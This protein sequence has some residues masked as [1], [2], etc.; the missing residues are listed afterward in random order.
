MLDK[1]NR[2]FGDLVIRWLEV[3][4]W[5]DPITWKISLLKETP[6][7]AELI[8]YEHPNHENPRIFDLTVPRLL[9]GS[10]L[11][12]ELILTDSQV[13]PAHVSLELRH[14]YWV[15]QDLGS[16]HG[17]S[18]NNEVIHEPYILE[19]KDIIQ[20]GAAKLEFHEEVIKPTK[21]ADTHPTIPI[22][23]A[24]ADE[25]PLGRVWL[26]QVAV[27]T[28]IIIIIIGLILFQLGVIQ[29]NDLLN[30]LNW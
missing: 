21:A 19:D 30:L 25:T 15:L 2:I 24:P 23:A 28:L 4:W 27:G 13:A 1:I 5:L 29:T 16:E 18:V 22:T 11:D 14:S 20:I 7:L 3:T 26:I 9:I 8:I 17:T 12:N 10:S 6:N